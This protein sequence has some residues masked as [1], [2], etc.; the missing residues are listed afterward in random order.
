MKQL[1]RNSIDLA[2]IAAEDID[3]VSLYRIVTSAP[4][5][6]AEA[7]DAK[8][9][10]GSVCYGLLE[11]AETKARE[12]KREADFEL[13]RDYWLKEFPGLAVE[14]RSV[15]V[16]TFTSMADCFLRGMLLALFCTD[17]NFRPED[18]FDGKIVVLNLPV[19]EHNGLGQFA[20]VLFKFVWQR[21]VERRIPPG[22]GWRQAQASIRPVFL[23]AD[24]SQF[25]AIPTTRSFRA[26]RVHRALARSI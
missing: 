4:R 13:T 22:L 20:Q 18:T 7:D 5:S 26:R 25:L 17:T 1:L 10:K 3:L 19:K 11:V 6:V 21:A 2:V 14:T 23:W 15:I 9:Q 16:S 8:W 24:E 12:I